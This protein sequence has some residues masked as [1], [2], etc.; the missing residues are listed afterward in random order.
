LQAA[1]PADLLQE[2]IDALSE[3]TEVL[4]Y[5]DDLTVKNK[6][7]TR[8]FDTAAIKALW[9]LQRNDG[10]CEYNGGDA[11]QMTIWH[12]LRYGDEEFT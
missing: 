12:T 3:R 2:I 8:E 7:V 9:Q 10:R 6:K 1:L 4:D 5:A 11:C